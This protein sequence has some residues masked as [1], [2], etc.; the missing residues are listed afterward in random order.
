MMTLNENLGKKVIYSHFNFE[1]VC[2][3]T[4]AGKMAFPRHIPVSWFLPNIEFPL[5]WKCQFVYM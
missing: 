2:L 5:D 4:P 1:P 3:I